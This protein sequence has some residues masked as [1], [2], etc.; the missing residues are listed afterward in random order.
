MFP[1]SLSSI[2]ELLPVRKE[3]I[4]LLHYSYELEVAGVEH[5][6]ASTLIGVQLRRQELSIEK[7]LLH[8]SEL[9]EVIEM[10]RRLMSDHSILSPPDLTLR[11]RELIH[12][13]ESLTAQV[14]AEKQLPPIAGAGIQVSE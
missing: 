14:A 4:D 7:L 10:Q 9:L 3:L 11:T 5:N 1:Q 6:L 13:Q 2:P 8:S 12:R